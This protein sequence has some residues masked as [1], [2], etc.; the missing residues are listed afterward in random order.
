MS[1][2]AHYI[3]AGRERV[4]FPGFSNRGNEIQG[5]AENIGDSI[6]IQPCRQRVSHG[7]REFWGNI[8]GTLSFFCGC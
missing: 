7:K 6:K 4:L 8:G 5:Q 2:C 3:A 1:V